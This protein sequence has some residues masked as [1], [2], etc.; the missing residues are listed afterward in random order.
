MYKSKSL[1]LEDK[2][3]REGYYLKEID[4][5]KTDNKNLNNDNKRLL[6]WLL[7]IIITFVITFISLVAVIC[8]HRAL[9]TTKP[10]TPEVNNVQQEVKQP[11]QTPQKQKP[12]QKKT[13]YNQRKY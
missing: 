12:V 10:E 3:G 1:L 6:K 11:L 7:T 4:T 13:T 8:Y 9:S 2:A 5:L